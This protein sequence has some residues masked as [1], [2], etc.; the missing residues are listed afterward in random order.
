MVIIMRKFFSIL[1]FVLSM[2][3]SLVAQNRYQALLD[4][5]SLHSPALLQLRSQCHADKS[6]AFSASLLPNPEVEMGFFWGSPLS[7]GNRIDLSVTQSL[8]FPSTMVR[9]NKERQLASQ[10]ADMAFA[11]DR[12]DLFLHIQLLASDWLYQ[13][14]LIQWFQLCLSNASD[15]AALYQKR[16]DAGDCSILDYNR[17]TVAVAQMQARLRSVEADQALLLQQ[18]VLLVGPTVPDLLAHLSFDTIVLPLD[19]SL[20]IN[21]A[22]A[23]DPQ[24]RYFEHQTS[25]SR[26]R[27]KVARA[28]CAPS[29][30]VGYASETVTSEAF[31]GVKVGITLPVWNN[32]GRITAATAATTAAAD[33]R[34]LAEQQLRVFYQGL[35]S[36]AH[37]LALSLD[38][39]RRTLALCNSVPLLRKALDA[40]ELSLEQYLLSLSFYNEAQLSFLATRHDLE[41]TYLQLFAFRLSDF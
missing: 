13:R 29:L 17:S 21:Q 39:L 7:I 22:L 23:A 14:A 5:A 15:I 11:V 6:A 12:R 32:A 8:P 16:M 35:F 37:T 20:C 25:L 2:S 33:Q 10:S 38:N 26:Q 4:E 28:E 30:L 24:L 36:K 27:E 31:R 18:L 3:L 41:Q 40:G 34:Q 9:I 1:L 19:S